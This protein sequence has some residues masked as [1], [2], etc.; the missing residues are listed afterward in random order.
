MRMG[1]S[2][3]FAVTRRFAPF[4]IPSFYWCPPNRNRA[5]AHVGDTQNLPFHSCRL[6]VRLV[7]STSTES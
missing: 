7:A 5:S 4:S 1:H 6:L 2:A 3:L